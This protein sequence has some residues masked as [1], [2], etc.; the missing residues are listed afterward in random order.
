MVQSLRLPLYLHRS[1]GVVAVWAMGA[2]WHRLGR[3]ARVAESVYAI[4]LKSM[5]RKGLWVQVPPRAFCG[6]RSRLI[7][8]PE[9]ALR[10][11]C[12]LD[13]RWR[14]HLQSQP[15]ARLPELKTTTSHVIVSSARKPESDSLP[16]AGSHR[17]RGRDSTAPAR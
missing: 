13:L 6:E 4:D 12:D 2:R 11:G 10:S 5:A 15:V 3:P 8:T 9:L 14:K 7:Q 16:I 17:D 1:N